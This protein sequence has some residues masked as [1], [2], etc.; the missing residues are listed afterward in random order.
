M[1]GGKRG[2]PTAPPKHINDFTK[3]LA[4]EVRIL[5]QEVGQLRDERRQLQYEIAELMAVKSKHGAGGEYTPDWAP[6]PGPEALPAPLPQPAIED[7]PR[8]PAPPAW[9]TIV[10]H[11]PRRPKHKAKSP[12]PQQITGAPAPAIPSPQLP[13][14]AQWKPNPLVTPQPR[15]GS[16]P[17][18]ATPPAPA[19]KDDGLFGPRT[20]PPK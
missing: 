1:N 15:M 4:S 11:E 6:K 8:E 13:A 5:L 19:P 12:P 3:A 10:K 9:R 14:W 7:V 2:Q 20:P 18:P 16:A 17:V